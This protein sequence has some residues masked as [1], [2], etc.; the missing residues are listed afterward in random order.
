V[1][2]RDFPDPDHRPDAIEDTEHNFTYEGVIYGEEN[3]FEFNGTT[4]DDAV[5][6]TGAELDY[7]EDGEEDDFGLDRDG[8]IQ[9]DPD[10]PSTYDDDE[11]SWDKLEIIDILILAIRH[12]IHNDFADGKI[13]SLVEKLEELVNMGIITDEDKTDL[14]YKLDKV[15]GHLAQIE[16]IK[17]ELKDKL[18]EVDD[19]LTAAKAA[20]DGGD[21][22]TAKA[23]LLEAKELI[24]DIIDEKE[25]IYEEL[26]AIWMWLCRVDLEIPPAPEVNTDLLG[27]KEK[28]FAEITVD[29][30]NAMVDAIVKALNDDDT[31]VDT[32]QEKILNAVAS[33]E[34]FVADDISVDHKGLRHSTGNTIASNLITSNLMTQDR[35]IG[36]VIECP[37]NT[38]V[39]NSITNEKVLPI[40]TELGYGE[41]HRLDIAMILLADECTIAY[42]A[43]EWVD[44]GIIRGGKWYRRDIQTEYVFKK[45]AAAAYWPEPGLYREGCITSYDEDHFASRPVVWVPV[46][47]VTSK[48]IPEGDGFWLGFEHS[49]RVLRNRIALNFFEYVGTSIDIVDAESNVIDENLFYN[50]ANGILFRAPGLHPWENPAV[51]EDP[52]TPE[53]EDPY[54]NQ[55]GGA[56]PNIILEKNDYFSGVAIHNDSDLAV[57]ANRDYT[58]PAGMVGH[59]TTFGL[60]NPPAAPAPNAYEN[61]GTIAKYVM[62]GIEKYYPGDD[63]TAILP[64][65]LEKDDTRFFHPDVELPFRGFDPANPELGKPRHPD[66]IFA[67]PQPV[68]LE[69][70]FP[71]GWN[72]VSSPVIP[73]DAD[74][75]A[76][77]GDDV[78]FLVMWEWNGTEYVEPTQIEGTKGYW[79]WLLEETTLDVCGFAPTTDVEFTLDQAGW[80]MISTLTTP[81]YLRHLKVVVGDEE[82]YWADAVEVGWVRPFAYWWDPIAG[83]YVVINPED[84]VLMPWR[85]YWIKTLVDDVTIV[86]PIEYS[87]E[88]PP[89]VP[90]ESLGIKATAVS[91]EL[92]PPPPPAPT[93]D[94]SAIDVV[95]EP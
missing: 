62:L 95:N 46:L 57:D 29:E 37:H 43:I 89:E 3:L 83:E 78:P 45:L 28:P 60:V 27:K 59:A 1:I 69:E 11:I 90:T 75:E 49:Q 76:V 5:T 80:H 56:G 73:S 18:E 48:V 58:P 53:M 70:T 66:D 64:P 50:C 12:E 31:V 79:I 47:S 38:I 67:V 85:G 42:N 81:V 68:C 87:L 7:Y 52:D 94:L 17:E 14:E 26:D 36:I 2:K 51:D 20:L 65:N 61:F 23:Q 86:L 92:P 77:F 93:P 22:D 88:N 91:D 30:R 4:H 71:G 54:E 10:D 19:K 9:N 33:R 41:F 15:K 13:D 82:K 63:A 6:V 39:N 84:G 16:Y 8:A 34:D 44:T 55:V 74:P 32:P 21:Y 24:E 72:M 35:Q 40:D 25:E